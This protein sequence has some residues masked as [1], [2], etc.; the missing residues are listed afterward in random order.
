MVMDNNDK[1]VES[2][3]LPAGDETMEIKEKT[4]QDGKKLAEKEIS[5]EVSKILGE[6]EEA[7]KLIEVTIHPGL[8][9]R[10]Q[11]WMKEGLPKKNKKKILE[12][13]PKKGELYTEAPKVNLKI[14]PA[15][16]EIAVKRD[17]HFVETQNEVGAA[18]S[19]LAAAV[20]MMLDEPEEGIDQEKFMRYLCD[21]GQLL[22]DVFYQQSVAR[23]SFITPL[24]NK[25]AK[26]TLE[27]TKA[28]QWLYGEKFGEQI[29]EAKSLEKA[30]AAIKAPDNTM[31][32][33]KP[34]KAWNQGNVKTPPARYRQVGYQRQQYAAYPKKNIIRFKPNFR[35]TTQFPKGSN[36]R[37]TMNQTVARK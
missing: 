23:K 17:N 21:T 1:R 19:A 16:T 36:K 13:Y 35:K 24:M 31:S 8:K 32:V 3:L 26:S 33:R 29:K 4:D 11:K 15:L 28:D 34:L 20:S 37:S 27:A 12:I 18:I 30:C 22:T 7:A 5:E 14:L 9:K 25:T 2:A 10:W 6:D